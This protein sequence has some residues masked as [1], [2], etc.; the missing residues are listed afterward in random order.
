MQGE[1]LSCKQAASASLIRRW[2]QA[3]VGCICKQ[4]MMAETVQI[5]AARQEPS[6]FGLLACF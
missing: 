2:R 1:H 4:S 6:K 5:H 3:A